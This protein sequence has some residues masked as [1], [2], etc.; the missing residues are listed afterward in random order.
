MMNRTLNPVTRVSYDTYLQL[1]KGKSI[2]NNRVKEESGD[3]FDAPSDYSLAH[4]ISQD[5]KMSQGT[6]LMFRRKFG[7][8]EI[9]KSQH[10]RFHEVLYIRQ[11]NRYILYMVTKPRYWQKPSLEDMFL[12]LQSLKSVCIELDIDKLAMPR[13]GSGID[14]LDW[15]AIRTMIRFVFKEIDIKIHVYSLTELTHAEKLEIIAEHHSSL[16]GGHR[17][18]NQTVKRIQTQF[19]WEGLEDNV[20]EYVSKCPSCQINKTCNKNV[21][22]PMVIS[23]TA[24]EPFEKVFIDVVGPLPRTHSNNAYILTMQCDLTKFSMAS[25]MENHEANTVAYHFVTSCVCLHGIPN[26]LVSDQGTEFLSKILAETCKLLK[27]K[28]CN[29]SPYHPQANGALERSHRTLGE[30]LRHFVDKDQTNWDTFIPYAMFVFNSS[31]HRSTGKQPYELLYGR[32]VTMPNSFTKPPEPRYNYEDFHV[33][34]KQ[35]LQVAHQ[36]ARD[37]LLEHKQKTKETYDQNQNQIIIHVGDRVLL[38]DNARKG[39]LSPKWLGP[40]EVIEL[41]AN[42]NVTLQKDRRRVTVHKN[43]IRPFVD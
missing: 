12:T 15:S 29:T 21:R 26:M 37:R 10:P 39:K 40:Y 2:V 19:N 35:K 5:V 7:N 17:G 24:T 20:K 6:A 25:P 43:L 8:V 23:T 41:K 14:Q 1:I 13:I 34:L 30:Y 36:I 4:C 3:L 27:I 42:E 9:L 33:E 31:E 28:K 16:L 11:E 18:I 38:K 32:T 22:Q